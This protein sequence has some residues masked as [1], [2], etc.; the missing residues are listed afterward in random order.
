MVSENIRKNLVESALGFAMDSLE[1]S[2]PKRCRYYYD[3]IRSQIYS[4]SKTEYLELYIRYIELQNM[5][6]AREI[7]Y[8]REAIK[9]IEMGCPLDAVRSYDMAQLMQTEGDPA[10]Y[11][12][13]KIAIKRKDRLNRKHD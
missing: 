3:E 4:L 13:I 9:L 1:N 11:P 10:Y 6:K 12:K 2:E 8:C 5:M 7:Y